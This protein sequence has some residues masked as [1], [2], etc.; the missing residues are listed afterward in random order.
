MQEG[1]RTGAIEPVT[2]STLSAALI[3]GSTTPLDALTAALGMGADASAP[4]V[5]G[6]ITHDYEF[7]AVELV[8]PTRMNKVG[9]A[10]AGFE[11]LGWCC[12]AQHM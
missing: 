1:V 7:A 5:P 6:T 8:K 3:S 11:L 9:C 4:I 2:A 12:T 10:L